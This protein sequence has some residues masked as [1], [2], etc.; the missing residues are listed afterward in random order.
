MFSSRY[1]GDEA[2][3][4]LEPADSDILIDSIKGSLYMSGTPEGEL[5]DHLAYLRKEL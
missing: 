5:K 1:L 2:S 3:K 4:I